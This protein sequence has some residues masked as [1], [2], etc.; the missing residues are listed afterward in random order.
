MPDRLYFTT[1]TDTKF[2]WSAYTWISV[3]RY[4]KNLGCPC[5]DVTFERM[6]GGSSSASETYSS[7]DLEKM[8]EGM[9]YLSQDSK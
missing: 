4:G 5:L 9:K 1:V 8:R 2:I 3:T 6:K 7:T